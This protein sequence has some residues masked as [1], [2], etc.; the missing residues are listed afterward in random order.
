MRL[1]FA[2]VLGIT[3]V[4]GAPANFHPA[5]RATP[6]V[7][8]VLT[9]Q[10]VPY[11]MTGF[12][13]VPKVA[14]EAHLEFSSRRVLRAVLMAVLVGPGFYLLAGAAVSSVA[15]VPGLIGKRFATAIALE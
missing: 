1:L 8:I 3:G 7:S 13:S 11:F 14:E 5:F 6:F 12:E 4:R 10:I 2:F 9:L 15:P